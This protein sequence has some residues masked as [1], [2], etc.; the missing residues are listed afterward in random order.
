[1][2]GLL[3]RAVAVT[4]MV[5]VIGV[6]GPGLAASAAGAGPNLCEGYAACGTAPF[7]DHGYPQHEG[8]PYWEMYAGDNCTN[9]V[10]YVESTA[11]GVPAPT[12]D[13]GNAD[14]WASTAAQNGALVDRTPAVGAVAVWPEDSA[15]VPGTGHVAVVEAVGPGGSYIDV[16]QQHM[17]ATD[18]YDWV[19]IY[20]HGGPNQWEQ[21]PAAFIHFKGVD[22]ALPAR[23]LAR[24]VQATKGTSAVTRRR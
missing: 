24:L 16:S 11:F 12:Y 20:L 5:A 17:I 18:G 21:W 6:S 19:R 2:T 1:M 13:L 8:T 10:A 4:S 7:T 23:R 22:A 9:Y 14:E 3:V 15:G